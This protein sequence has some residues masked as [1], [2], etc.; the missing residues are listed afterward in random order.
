MYGGSVPLFTSSHQVYH[1]SWALMVNRKK[2][3]KL[4][5]LSYDIKKTWQTWRWENTLKW[6]PMLISNAL[7][8]NSNFT[9][10]KLSAFLNWM[11]QEE[12]TYQK[13]EAATIQW[14]YE[15]EYVKKHE[16][17]IQSPGGSPPMNPFGSSTLESLLG[18]CPFLTSSCLLKHLGSLVG[19]MGTPTGLQVNPA[20]AFEP[21]GTRSLHHYYPNWNSFQ[22]HILWHTHCEELPSQLL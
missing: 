22:L 16:C 14:T 3:V 1:K 4:Q 15:G 13:N 10:G 18:I 17:N 20:E 2:Q 9:V 12:G 5:D 11:Q 19:P 7:I 6:P 8:S 21:R